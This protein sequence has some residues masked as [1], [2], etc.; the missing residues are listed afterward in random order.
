MRVSVLFNFPNRS[1][2]KVV[3]PIFE[4]D[5]MDG[6]PRFR[7]SRLDNTLSPS[8]WLGTSTGCVIVINLNIIYEPRNISGNWENF[9]EQEREGCLVTLVVPSGSVFR[10][11]GRILHISFLDHKGVILPAPSEKWDTK[12]NWFSSKRTGR[13]R[14]RVLQS[15]SETQSTERWFYSRSRF[16]FIDSIT[17]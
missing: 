15:R 12:S 16:E 6:E 5:L 13:E 3:C 4:R 8:V 14:T 9:L 10:L 17:R 1:P 11:C 7:I 2:T